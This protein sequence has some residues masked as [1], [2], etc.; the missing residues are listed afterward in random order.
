MDE[1]KSKVPGVFGVFVA[2]PKDAKAPEP[3][4]KAEEAL[5]DGVV[6]PVESGEIALNGFE[7]P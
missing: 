4:P 5:V 1:L 3:K 7:R 6:T 2:D